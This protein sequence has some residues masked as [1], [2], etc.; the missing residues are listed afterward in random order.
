MQLIRGVFLAKY[1]PSP[2]LVVKLWP[3]VFE[4]IPECPLK[5]YAE[6]LPEPF[7]KAF[8]RVWLTLS[9]G[10]GEPFPKGLAIHE[11]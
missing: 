3:K 6:G 2:T 5:L 11:Q 4:L 1:E 7:Q 8:E 10:F 9:K